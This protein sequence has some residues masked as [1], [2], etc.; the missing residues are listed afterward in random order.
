MIF[1]KYVALSIFVCSMLLDAASKKAQ[2]TSSTI[3]SCE[4]YIDDNAEA[5]R[6]EFIEQLP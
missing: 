2:H 6:K 1:S 3:S 4:K 5:H